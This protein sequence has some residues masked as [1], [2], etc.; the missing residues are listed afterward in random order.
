MLWISLLSEKVEFWESEG[1]LITGFGSFCLVE[2]RL[3]VFNLRINLDVGETKSRIGTRLYQEFLKGLFWGLLYSLFINDI[4]SCLIIENLCLFADDS[5]FSISNLDG[6]KLRRFVCSG[7]L[8]VT[9][10]A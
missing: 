5:S 9:V 8:I 1:N 7:K 3:L 2:A 10:T 4:Q 6:Q